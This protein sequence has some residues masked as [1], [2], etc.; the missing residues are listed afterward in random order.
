VE[1]EVGISASS[2]RNGKSIASLRKL[3]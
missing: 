1:S 3:R 2:L